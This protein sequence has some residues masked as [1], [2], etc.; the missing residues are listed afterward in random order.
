MPSTYF[1]VVFWFLFLSCSQKTQTTRLWQD[2]QVACCQ[3][4]KQLTLQMGQHTSLPFLLKKGII[5]HSFDFSFL[6]QASC[7]ES[8]TPKSCQDLGAV[9]II[10]AHMQQSK[11]KFK[12]QNCSIQLNITIKLDAKASKVLFLQTF[13]CLF[14]CLNSS[15]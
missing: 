14:V 11:F 2:K 1:R 5:R 3:S 4:K 9:R 12:S 6:L 8:N 10:K 15:Y 13:Y 7:P